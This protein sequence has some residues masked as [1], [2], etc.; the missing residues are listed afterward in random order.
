[1]RTSRG[2]V[3][4]LINLVGQ[5]E[6]GWD[7]GKNDAAPLPGITLRLAPVGAPPALIWAT[8][9]ADNG[10]ARTLHGRA[11]TAGPQTDSLSA[12]Q[13]HASYDLPTLTTWALVLI[14]D[15]DLA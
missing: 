2:L 9:D 12:G 6:I 1:M 4:H 8:P 5:D 11:E 7:A 10:A 13:V 14:G 3:L 15:A